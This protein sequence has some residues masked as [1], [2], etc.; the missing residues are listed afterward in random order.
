MTM[1]EIKR[2]LVC[3]QD[4]RLHCALR[5]SGWDVQVVDCGV[6]FLEKDERRVVFLD[7]G[8]DYDTIA[9]L[10]SLHGPRR[11]ELFVVVLSERYTTGDR[12]QAW[13]ESADLVLHPDDLGRVAQ[14]VEQGWHEKTRFYARFRELTQTHGDS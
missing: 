5:A 2:S 7:A 3:S 10:R 8:S 13:R 14:L 4:E 9:Y 12:E 1:T 6:G 11:R